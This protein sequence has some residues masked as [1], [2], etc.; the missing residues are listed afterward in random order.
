MK[1][2]GVVIREAFFAMGWVR[3][4]AYDLQQLVVSG[5]RMASEQELR[6][7]RQRLDQLEGTLHRVR[8]QRGG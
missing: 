8:R 4:A 6:V 5:M 1:L 2:V 7:L 3:R